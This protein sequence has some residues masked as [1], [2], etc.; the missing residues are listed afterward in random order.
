MTKLTK[1]LLRLQ[2]FIE[3][4]DIISEKDGS[5]TFVLHDLFKVKKDGSPKNKVKLFQFL[6]KVSE[7]DGGQ[8]FEDDDCWFLRITK[9][10]KDK[11]DL[12][13]CEEF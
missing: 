8:L 10:L 7:V 12:S 2:K 5:I 9:K 13:T 11:L 3:G 1:D 4:S 6:E